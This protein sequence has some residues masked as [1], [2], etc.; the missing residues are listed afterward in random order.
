MKFY[1]LR[2]FAVWRPFIRWAV[3][4]NCRDGI[5]HRNHSRH[6]QNF[7]AGNAYVTEAKRQ[8]SQTIGGAAIDMPAGPLKYW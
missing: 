7:R 4:G 6:R 3:P 1:M 5:R 8:V 2:N